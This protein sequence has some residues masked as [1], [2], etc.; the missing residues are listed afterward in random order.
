MGYVSKED[1]R[2]SI[3]G[4]IDFLSGRFKTIERD[5]EA[6]H[7]PRRRGA[8]VRAGHARAQ[9][10]ARGAL[11]D[12]APARRQGVD[13]HPRRD[14]RG[15]RRARRQRPGLPGARRRALRPPLLLP[16]KRDRARR[17]GGG[18]GVHAPVLRRPHLD[19]GA[20]RGAA[21]AGRARGARPSAR[22]S[23]VADPCACTPPSAATSTA[24]SSSPTATPCSRSTR[25]ACATSAATSAAPRRSK[26][27]SS[28][29]ASTRS[30]CASSAST[31]QTSAAPTQSPRWSSSR[32]A[33]PRNPTTAASRFARFEGSDD[34]ASMAEV[35]SRRF[36]QWEQPG[37][38]LPARPLPRCELRVASQHRRDRWRQGPAGGRPHAPRGLSRM[39]GG[40]GR[41]RQAR[42]GGVPSGSPRAPPTRPL[43]AR[44]AASAAHP[45]RGPPF[46]HHPPPHH[47][48][49]AP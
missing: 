11:L 25:S 5:L 18:R 24:S 17:G 10:P 1:Y 8:G 43:H 38:L 27:C 49:T 9:S 12:G 45:R 20:A 3:D 33:R 4:V 41:A 31:F 28:R 15:G 36:A 2:H 14:R 16:V 34:Y 37:R 30:R 48:A 13:R 46:R 47:V 7:A 6:A 22:A 29:L 26:G 23:G 39:R 40:R 19:P 32:G 44:A 42:R 35:L 21:R